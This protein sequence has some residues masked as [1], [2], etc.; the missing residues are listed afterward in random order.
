[1]GAVET[2]LTP[3]TWGPL[4]FTGATETEYVVSGVSPGTVVE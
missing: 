3:D 2:L 4:A 1:M